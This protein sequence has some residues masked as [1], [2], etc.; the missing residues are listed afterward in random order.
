MLQP[1][2]QFLLPSRRKPAELWIGFEG[3]ALLVGRQVFILAQPLS[4]VTT[5]V[6]RPGAASLDAY[7]WRLTLPIRAHCHGGRHAGNN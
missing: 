7:E 2:L 3:P 5:L 1:L 6:S 4:G